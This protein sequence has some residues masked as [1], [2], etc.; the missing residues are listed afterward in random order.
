MAVTQECNLLHVSPG[1]ILLSLLVGSQDLKIESFLAI[2]SMSCKKI[3][4]D[5][6][7]AV[8]ISLFNDYRSQYY[9]SL[10]KFIEIDMHLFSLDYN[11]CR[12]MRCQ[13]LQG[14]E[15]EAIDRRL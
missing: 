2:K 8:Q 4:R 11:T 14:L 13:D 15:I 12:E 1:S 10:T 7:F 3:Q 5:P 6:L 9:N